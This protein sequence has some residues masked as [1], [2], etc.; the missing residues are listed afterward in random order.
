MESGCSLFLCSVITFLA[1]ENARSE[2]ALYYG[3]KLLLASFWKKMLLTLLKSDFG[4]LSKFL[5]WKD[6][7]NDIFSKLFKNNIQNLVKEGF[8]QLFKNNFQNLVLSGIAKIIPCHH[9]KYRERVSMFP[10]K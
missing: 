3:K 9:L 6:F 8:Q 2:D 1:A 7:G 4:K 5:F 10:I